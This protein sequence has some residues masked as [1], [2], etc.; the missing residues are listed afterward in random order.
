MNKTFKK[1]NLYQSV[2]DEIKA[3]KNN[4]DYITDNKEKLQDF[5]F[6]ISK[7]VDRTFHFGRFLNKEV[8]E[9][10]RNI[11]EAVSYI[12]SDIGYCQGMNFIAGALL[13]LTDSEEISF[14]ILLKFL[15]DYEVSNLFTKVDNYFYL[16]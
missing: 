8:I 14:L 1:E 6:D 9:Q 3:I 4:K 12:Q 5:F 11:L 7:D 15:K 10:L 16:K 2:L 13:D